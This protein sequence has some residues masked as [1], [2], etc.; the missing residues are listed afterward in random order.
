MSY[1]NSLDNIFKNYMTII[2]ND[3]NDYHFYN[4]FSY[5]IKNLYY[6]QFQKYEEYIEEYSKNYNFELLNITL[7][8]GKY[9]SA[10][11]KDEYKD[12]EFSF[13]FDYIELYDKYQD[14]YKTNLI[15]NLTN[16]RDKALKSYKLKYDDYLKKL[17]NS[18]NYVSKDFILELNNNYSKCL[19]YSKFTLDEIILED[20][21]NWEKY[22]N[23]TQLLELY[24]NS[25]NDTNSSLEFEET[26]TI[27]IE[28]LEE[29]TYF[30][31]TEYWLY[32]DSNI[33]LIIL[34]LYLKI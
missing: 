33:F 20:Q 9:F 13:I 19:N 16:L 28:D 24:L 32:C 1:Y 6:S 29:I 8:L 5:S 4:A 27:N 14:F 22:E 31:E 12:F 2:N 26:E 34:I 17:K 10:I 25:T 11:L 21:M 15:N 30:N 3:L 18:K 23:Y 7:D